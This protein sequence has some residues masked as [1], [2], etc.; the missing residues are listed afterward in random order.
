[1]RLERASL[2]IAGG[3]PSELGMELAIDDAREGEVQHRD[4]RSGVS[5]LVDRVLP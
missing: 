1:M 5:R 4:I 3:Q 2:G